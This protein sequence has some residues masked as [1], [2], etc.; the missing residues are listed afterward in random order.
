M[1]VLPPRCSF[2]T[3]KVAMVREENYDSK[4][5]PELSLRTSQ[6]SQICSELH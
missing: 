5:I 4:N 1:M 2:L 3:A 6:L